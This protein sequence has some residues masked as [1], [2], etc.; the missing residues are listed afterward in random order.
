MSPLPNSVDISFGRFLQEL[1][2]GYEEMAYEFRAF[3]R[4]RK[5]RTPS[6]L[7]QVVLLYCG[8]DLSLRGTAGHLTMGHARMTDTAIHRRLK[9]CGPW[10]KAMV[11]HLYGGRSA[12]LVPGHLRFV[13]IDGSTVQAPGAEGIS[14]R[15]HLA[16]DLVEMT[17]VHAEVSDAHCGEGLPHFP[18]QAGDVAVLD[19]GYNQP[20]S[21]IAAAEAGIG[22][23]VRHNP[24]GMNLY[25]D[26]MRKVDLHGWLK[27]RQTPAHRLVRVA[28]RARGHYTGAVLHAIPLPPAEAAKARQK[29]RR[30][31][32]K[33][34][35]PVSAGVPSGRLGSDRHHRASCRTGYRNRGRTLPGALA[36]RTDYQ[37]PQKP[38]RSGQAARAGRGCPGGSL[39]LWQTA[40]YLGVGKDRRPTIWP[41][42]DPARPTTSGDVV[43]TVG[44]AQASLG[45]RHSSG[46]SLADGKLRGLPASHEGTFPSEKTANTARSGD[47]AIGMV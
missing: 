14:Y 27:R 21:L 6:E 30:Q 19:R 32:K 8:L 24:H 47:P 45:D 35:Y 36:S 22:W 5:I 16:M 12:S 13:A 28:D 18:L 4:G 3:A 38:A 23:V 10:L 7:L 9:A 41:A 33:R 20:A 40:L 11:Q 26:R 31:A 34:L 29:L 17:L 46:G 25:D 1:P 44:D 43:A 15:L 2:S 39:P 42:L 37:T